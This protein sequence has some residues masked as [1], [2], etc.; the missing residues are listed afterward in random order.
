V[1][2]HL[3]LLFTTGVTLERERERERARAGVC[4]CARAHKRVYQ[5]AGS[6]LRHSIYSC[7]IVDALR[8]VRDLQ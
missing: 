8:I 1:N 6:C 5:A 4:V 3:V 2:N 7:L